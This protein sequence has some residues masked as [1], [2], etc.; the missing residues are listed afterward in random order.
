MPIFHHDGYKIFYVDLDE[1]KDTTKGLPLVFV[2]GAGSSHI[3]WTLQ[4][5]SFKKTNRVIAL[6]LPGHGRS[7]ESD[8]DISIE[9][10]FAPAVAALVNHLG[11]ENFIL[12]GHSMGGGIVMSYALEESFKQ[13]CAIALVDT[14]S[15]LD[16]KKLALGLIEE[17]LEDF[18]IQFDFEGMGDDLDGFPMKKFQ[19]SIKTVDPK[20]LLRDLSACDDFDVTDQLGSIKVPAFVIV[21]EDDDIATQD[22]ARKLEAALPRAD[23]AVVKQANHRPMVEEPATF[24]KMFRSFIKWVQEKEV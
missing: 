16:L 14:S 5:L 10:Y 17:T 6:D 20:T 13:P 12:V 7:G 21:G 19:D 23:V 1:R 11:L 15:N 8:G 4:L 2:H 3:I 24:N 22:M 18:S 9:G